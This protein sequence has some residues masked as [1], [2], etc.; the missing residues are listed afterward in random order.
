MTNA[1]EEPTHPQ[2]AESVV[3]DE[4]LSGAQR[5]RQSWIGYKGTQQIADV[6]VVELN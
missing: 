5:F 3:N 6:I 2:V 4:Y 1:S